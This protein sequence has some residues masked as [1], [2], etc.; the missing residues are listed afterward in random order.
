MNLAILDTVGHQRRGTDEPEGLLSTSSRP[1]LTI[2]RTYSLPVGDA[3]GQRPGGCPTAP[4]RTPT[5]SD[6]R[7]REE[8]MEL[9]RAIA[10]S[11]VFTEFEHAFTQATG[12]PV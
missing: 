12:L 3:S 4:Q 9:L 6:F 11:K 10:N 5:T 7:A 2:D 8:N 1:S